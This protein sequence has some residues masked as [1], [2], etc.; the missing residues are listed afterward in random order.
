MV[1]L[2]FIPFASPS[3]G[4]WAWLALGALF[5]PITGSH[6]LAD[7]GPTSYEVESL[8]GPGQLSEGAPGY[9]PPLRF[10]DQCCRDSIAF[11]GSFRLSHDFLQFR[12][13]F[14]GQSCPSTR[15]GPHYVVAWIDWN[16]NH[17]WEGSERVYFAA[18]FFGTFSGSNSPRACEGDTVMTPIIQ[19][20]A[21]VTVDTT[22]M[23]IGIF[24]D[25][26]YI[27]PCTNLSY[28]GN[29]VDHRIILRN[30]A[31]VQVEAEGAETRI[32][33]V[34]DPVWHAARAFGT[35]DPVVDR[36]PAE[37]TQGRRME[38]KGRLAVLR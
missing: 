38:W 2:S 6:V 18:P 20:P 37:D 10:L 22:W 11:V 36:A 21:S 24:Y 1:R 33:E 27:A 8:V 29:T 30:A 16:S 12:I 35:C 26:D 14:G 15:G 17:N 32:Q 28:Y 5:L 25:E 13:R 31:V 19:I 34:Q 3:R 7:G 4:A 23:R 9:C